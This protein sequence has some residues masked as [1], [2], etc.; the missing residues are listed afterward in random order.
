MKSV[1]KGLD[2]EEGLDEVW[3]KLVNF[4]H[5]DHPLYKNEYLFYLHIT[6]INI[7]IIFYSNVFK[8]IFNI[9]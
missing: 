3:V 1:T 2:E 8:I 4:C 7:E 9:I 5:I 6:I